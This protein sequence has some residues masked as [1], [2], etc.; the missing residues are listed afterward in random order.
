MAEET[1]NNN[2]YIWLYHRNKQVKTINDFME[3]EFIY[4]V[5]PEELFELN[6]DVIFQQMTDADKKLKEATL[7]KYP[8]SGADSKVDYRLP[9][10]C[11]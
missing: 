9:F 8:E 6:R 11:N 3:K 2:D 4:G 7:V 5:T 10:P 1:H